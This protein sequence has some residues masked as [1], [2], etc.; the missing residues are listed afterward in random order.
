MTDLKD[1]D[2]ACFIVNEV[3]NAK[4]AL[5]YSV[6]I[7]MAGQLFGT[8]RPRVSRQPLNTVDEPLTVRLR[9]YR[10]KLLAGRGLDQNS[11]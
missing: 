5:S 3:D 8:V 6:A 4:V 9:R 7:G 10:G 11:I 2:S 1:C